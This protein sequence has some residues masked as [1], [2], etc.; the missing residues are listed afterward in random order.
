METE[1]LICVAHYVHTDAEL[2][3]TCGTFPGKFPNVFKQA[4][5]CWAFVGKK[6]T[7]LLRK[8]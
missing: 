4:A 7:S 2:C 1:T 6:G 5:L 3:V 8:A